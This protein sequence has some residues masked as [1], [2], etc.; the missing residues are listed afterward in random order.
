MPA[1]VGSASGLAAL[2]AG[3]GLTHFLR[4]GFYDAMIPP[5]LPGPAR[6]WTYGSAVAEI[7]IGA[8]VALPRTRRV[9]GLAAAALFVGVLPA[10]VQM[11]LDA[12]TDPPLRRAAVLLRLPMQ[13]SLVGWALRVRREAA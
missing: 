3:A 5:Q 10:N 6:A 2:L 4:P 9:G 13:L 1:T 8:A 7:V 12:R 11:A